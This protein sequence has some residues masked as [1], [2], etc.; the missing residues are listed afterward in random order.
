MAQTQTELWRIQLFGRWG[1][2]VFTQYVRDAPLSQLHDLAKEI[3]IKSSL[4]SAKAELKAM[5]AEIQAAKQDNIQAPLREQPVACL[6]DCAAAACIAPKPQSQTAKPYVVNTAY[7]GKVHRVD[8][9]GQDTPHY[10]W[11]TRCHWYFARRSVEY[12]LTDNLP[13]GRNPCSKC[14]TPIQIENDDELSSS[15]S[16]ES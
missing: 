9:C 15:S 11:R 7:N 10:I 12:E 14:F 5:L 4:A 2:S 8:E 3:S 13:A 1:S 16:S 6:L